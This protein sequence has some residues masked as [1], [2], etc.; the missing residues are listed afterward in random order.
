MHRDEIGNTRE[1][2]IS[3]KGIEVKMAHPFSEHGHAVISEG[4]ILDPVGIVHQIL[5]E[6]L[7]LLDLER[8]FISREGLLQSK[9]D[10]K[11]VDG[12]GTKI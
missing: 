2:S 10:V 1:A 7:T 12:L 11:K 8:M 6:Q 5:R 3:V 9:L 4:F